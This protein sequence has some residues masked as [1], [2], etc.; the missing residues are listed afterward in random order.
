VIDVPIGQLPVPRPSPA[1][2]ENV[3]DP[4]SLRVWTI[5]I[6]KAP[7]AVYPG[8]L[9]PTRAPNYDPNKDLTTYSVGTTLYYPFRGAN[10]VYDEPALPHTRRGK[11]A[12]GSLYHFTAELTAGTVHVRPI[13][14]TDNEVAVDAPPPSQAGW[15][16]ANDLN[17]LAEYRAGVALRSGSA[18][19]LLFE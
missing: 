9:K 6:D 17:D 5:R 8:I 18:C 16:L 4:S 3:K 13:V 14:S 15:L 7:G 10:G 19:T 2:F 1:G 12:A 11:D